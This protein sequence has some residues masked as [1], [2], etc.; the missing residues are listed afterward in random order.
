[1]NAIMDLTARATSFITAIQT[2]LLKVAI[3]AGQRSKAISILTL[4]PEDLKEIL[5][6]YT[7]KEEEEHNIATD[8]NG[9][10]PKV[11]RAI[12]PKEG[13]T[14]TYE[15]EDDGFSVKAIELIWM[16]KK[17][18]T[19]KIIADLSLAYAID[20]SVHLVKWI[21]ANREHGI[22][23]LQKANGNY[24]T[25]F[26]WRETICKILYA[27]PNERVELAKA[28]QYLPVQIVLAL[29]AGNYT[30]YRQ[31]I[32]QSWN[33]KE[34]QK[35]KLLDIEEIKWIDQFIAA[36]TTRV[37]PEILLANSNK[38]YDWLNDASAPLS[39]EQ[40]LTWN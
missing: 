14:P 31:R 22:D 34:E 21:N 18:T 11:Q 26:M 38:L 36:S 15:K 6:T 35:L 1:M 40:I 23:E 27:F 13:K 33:M 29:G 39:F 8:Q 3:K 28:L 4:S 9:K 25:P 32:L 30:A 16:S 7:R 20:L 37:A 17:K 19:P 12:G 2:T 24:P 5:T 10:G